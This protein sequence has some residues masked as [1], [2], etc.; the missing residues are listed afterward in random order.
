M[1]QAA[2]LATACSYDCVNRPNTYL[3]SKKA[4]N[5]EE[6][7]KKKFAEFGWDNSYITE[8]ISSDYANLSQ[9]FPLCNFFFEIS[10]DGKK[11]PLHTDEFKQLAASDYAFNQ[12]IQSG[13]I[14]AESIA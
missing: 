2:A 11:V 1:V 10:K 4:V 6:I 14:I 9:D 7:I 5:L 8:K 3:A 12:A 13:I